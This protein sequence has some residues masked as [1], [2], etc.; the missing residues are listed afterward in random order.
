MKINAIFTIILCTLLLQG[1]ISAIVIGSTTIAIKSVTD[2]RTIG[3]QIDDGTLEIRITN[4]L[5]K[6]QQ[7]KKNARVIVT[8]YQGKI[9]LTGQALKISLSNRAK[10]IAS[11]TE[12]IHEIYNEIRQGKPI[13]LTTV[14]LDAWITTKINFQLLAS[15]LVKLS[16]IK[17]ITENGEVFLL[18]LV[19]KQEGQSAARIASKISK[20]KH[21]TTAFTFI[22]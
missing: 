10:Q 3:T 15:N 20:V 9:L 11:H 21:V 7:L 13:N 1:C 12:G 5:N 2:P 16:N 14:S 19:T 6:D 18:G 22:K 8:V 4:A 17:I